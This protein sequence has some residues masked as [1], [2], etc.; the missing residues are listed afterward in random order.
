LGMMF[1]RT[2][3]L[4]TLL[5]QIETLMCKGLPIRGVFL[6][7]VAFDLLMAM[8]CPRIIENFADAVQRR[9]GALPG[10]ITMNHPKAVAMLCDQIGL[11]EPWICA[12]YNLAGFRTHPSQAQVEASFASRRSRN[13]A[14]SVFASGSAGGHASLDY[15]IGKTR[16]GGVDAILF[17]SANAGHIRANTAAI[18][19]P[20]T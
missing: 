12:N 4:I 14:M 9:L 20:V 13:I 17:G 2:R 6:Q 3:G 1:G 19:A 7:N 8:D 5:T 10:F 18:L 11:H 16:G 15:V